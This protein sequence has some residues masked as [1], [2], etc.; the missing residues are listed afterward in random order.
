MIIKP[1]STVYPRS[2]GTLLLRSNTTF[3]V[4]YD[5]C[6]E[7]LEDRGVTDC[8]I[9]LTL[10]VSYSCTGQYES[11]NS[12]VVGKTES[13]FTVDPELTL[14]RSLVTVVGE[15]VPKLVKMPYG[16]RNYP[17]TRAT[18]ESLFAQLD[19]VFELKEKV[20]DRNQRECDHRPFECVD[21][22]QSTY[23]Q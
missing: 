2:K 22:G 13:P 4:D 1:I 9:V 18:L 20:Q 21:Y 3:I 6:E 11:T 15:V 10:F 8:L 19:L 17:L 23:G 12:V 7:T 16:K 5:G 14:S